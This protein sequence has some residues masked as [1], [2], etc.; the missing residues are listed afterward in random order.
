VLGIGLSQIWR[1]VGVT[2]SVVGAAKTVYT[3]VLGKGREVQ[4]PADTLIQLQPAP[5]SGSTP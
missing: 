3:N 2:L 5:G 4:F 1:P